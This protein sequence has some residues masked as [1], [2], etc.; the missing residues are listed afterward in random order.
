MAQNRYE[1]AEPI[2]RHAIDVNTALTR[3]DPDDV[4]IRLDLAKCHNNLG[5]LLIDHGDARQAA[6]SFR[7]SQSISEALVK[8]YPNKPRYQDQLAHS[9]DNLALALQTVDPAKVEQTYIPRW[10]STRSW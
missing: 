2:L 7:Q 9:L 5:K 3:A 10:R 4:Q 8:A 6:T 1:S